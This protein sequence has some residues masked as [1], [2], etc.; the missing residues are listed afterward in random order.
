MFQYHKY[1][2][3]KFPS[4]MER[5]L[6]YM[7]V[8]ERNRT[9]IGAIKGAYKKLDPVDKQTIDECVID[10]FRNTRLGKQTALEAIAA[11]GMYA[12]QNPEKFIDLK[13]EDNAD[14]RGAPK[15]AASAK[16]DGPETKA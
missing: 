7:T 13:G 11:I 16:L 3:L 14:T 6:A 10:L 5:K 15:S 12:A 4:A 1:S 8:S 2:K 9:R